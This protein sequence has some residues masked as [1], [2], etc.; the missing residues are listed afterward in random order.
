VEQELG[1]AVATRARARDR[2]GV[3]EK[4]VFLHA[5][6]AHRTRRR[7]Q[8]GDR[9]VRAAAAHEVAGSN[10]RHRPEP[11]GVARKVARRDAQVE[12]RAARAQQEIVEL[13][14]ANE[15]TPAADPPHDALEADVAG[16]PLPEAAGIIAGREREG[17]P[18]RGRQPTAAQLHA[19]KHRAIDD[20][21]AGAAAREKAGAAASGRPAPDDHDI[22][23]VRHR[24][25]RGPNAQE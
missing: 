7:Q 1:L 24:G 21:D 6:R 9:T 12:G 13:E 22:H 15:P 5:H 17:V 2:A 20:R 19:R 11:I 23:L 3:G 25:P 18:D 14:A 10:A 4:L 8:A 16:L